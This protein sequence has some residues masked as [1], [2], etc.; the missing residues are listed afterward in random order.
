[1]VFPSDRAAS[2][3]SYFACQGGMR[4]LAKISKVFCLFSFV[5]SSLF[6]C[7]LN[8][9][10]G[11]YMQGLTFLFLPAATRK[12]I[13]YTRNPFLGTAVGT[14]VKIPFLKIKNINKRRSWK[15]PE[16]CRT[17]KKLST[18]GTRSLS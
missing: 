11:P 5:F 1:M 7:V 14:S 13:E 17:G 18:L 10:H 8:Q 16:N 3:I 4:Q 2:H 9:K 15:F 12:Q 6:K